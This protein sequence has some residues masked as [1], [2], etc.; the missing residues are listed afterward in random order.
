MSKRK[1]RDVVVRCAAGVHKVRLRGG[2]RFWAAARCPT[3]GAPV[4]PTRLARVGR[5]TQNLRRPASSNPWDRGLWWGALGYLA[6][7]ATTALLIQTRGDEWWAVTVLLFG[8]RWLFL[9]PLVPL[10]IVAAARDRVLLVPSAV[11]LLLTLGPLMGFHT[12]WRRIFVRDRGAGEVTVVTFNVRTG[13]GLSMGPAGLMTAWGADVAA[14][15]ECGSRLRDEIREMVG[16]HVDID[17]SLCLVS[18]FPILEAESMEREVIESAGGSGLVRSYML[19]GPEAPF[20]LTNVH[21]DTP[22]AGLELIRSGRFLEGIRILKLK[23]LIRGIEL[24]RAHRFAQEHSGPHVVVGDFNTPDESQA[25]RQAF[26]GWTNAFAVAG[27]GVGGTRLNGWIR[28]RIDHVVVD[29][30]WQ[31]V[32]ARPGADAGS[33][34]LPFIATIRRRPRPDR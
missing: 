14:F 28:V 1:A 34:H 5:A 10:G 19:A 6:V 24:R 20:R 12:G 9:V 7:I 17:R 15:Q 31:V 26:G 22:R 8:P 18:R 30:E 25:Y 21:L 16:W 13:D 2:R 29:R 4:D 23:S 32:E 3:C 11:A 33:D 27:S